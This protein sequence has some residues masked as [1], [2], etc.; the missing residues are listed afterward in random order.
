MIYDVPVLRR[1]GDCYYTVEFSDDADLQANFRVLAMMQHLQRENIPGILDVIP[2]MRQ[3]GIVVEADRRKPVYWE[4]LLTEYA[5]QVTAPTTITSR[6]FTLPAWYRDPWSVEIAERNGE[7]HGVD[8]IAENHG[9]STDEAI[10]K[11][12]ETDHWLACVG[13]GPGC[14]FAY[15]LDTEG[16]T[17]PKLATAR[18]FTHVRT[19]CLGGKCT[20]AL[21]LDGPSG[22]PMLGRFA[23]PIYEPIPTT[24]MFPESGVLFLAGDRH[25]Y[26][27]IEGDEY[28]EIQAKVIE[29]TY[30]Y[31]V[32]EEEFDVSEYSRQRATVAA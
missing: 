20:A 2:T 30:R 6:L 32:V 26:R 28:E 9:I 21:P 14:F 4:R 15:P 22:Y 27:P 7:K 13:W 11:H 5:S 10:R 12:S 29:G 31:D 23:T 17:L 16:V 24:H 19:F 25:R 3:L 1:L 18:T 8:W